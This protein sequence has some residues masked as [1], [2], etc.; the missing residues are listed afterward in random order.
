MSADLCAF[1]VKHFHV[2]KKPVEYLEFSINF[3]TDKHSK[4]T[5]NF[6]NLSE[7]KKKERKWSSFFLGQYLSLY[8]S[9]FCKLKGYASNHIL[10]P[11]PVVPSDS[12]VALTTYL[13][14]PALNSTFSPQEFHFFSVNRIKLNKLRGRKG[15]VVLSTVTVC[16]KPA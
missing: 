15:V 1:F 10:L 14:L 5:Q 7:E 16:V 12:T 3:Y 6:L 4:L 2:F 11:S 9:Y 13:S 8:Y